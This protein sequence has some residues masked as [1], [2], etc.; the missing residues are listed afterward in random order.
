[1]CLT[2]YAA[3]HSPLIILNDLQFCRKS[4]LLLQGVALE[5]FLFGT[6]LSF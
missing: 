4:V 2:L 3:Y 6:V 1:M 5:H